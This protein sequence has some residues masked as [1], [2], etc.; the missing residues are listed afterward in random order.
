MSSTYA[1]LRLMLQRLVVAAEAAQVKPTKANS[2][3]LSDITAEARA[4]AFARPGRR[5]PK[6]DTEA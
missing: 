2:K 6:K 4:I 5:W 1:T 3:T